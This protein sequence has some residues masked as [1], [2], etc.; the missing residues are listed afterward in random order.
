MA[1]TGVFNALHAAMS[2]Y[3]GRFE[4][5]E[6]EARGVVLYDEEV[7]MEG[8]PEEHPDKTTRMQALHMKALL[9]EGRQAEEAC[10]DETRALQR[11]QRELDAMAVGQRRSIR[12]Q[13][14]SRHALKVQGMEREAQELRQQ[15]D[16]EQQSLDHGGPDAAEKVT[17][18][19]DDLSAKIRAAEGESREMT[20]RALAHSLEQD[21]LEVGKSE[22]EMGVARKA[23]SLARDKMSAEAAEKDGDLLNQ[24]IKAQLRR[25]A[26]LQPGPKRTLKTKALQIMQQTAKDRHAQAKRALEDLEGELYEAAATLP[27]PTGGGMQ[28]RSTLRLVPGAVN[29]VCVDVNGNDLVD[30][31]GLLNPLYVPPIVAQ[32]REYRKRQATAMQ[33]R[34][35]GKK[36][37]VM[38]SA[39]SGHKVW[40]QAVAEQEAKRRTAAKMPPSKWK[41]AMQEA[42]KR[43]EAAVVATERL[44]KEK[45]SLS[46]SISEKDTALEHMTQLSEGPAGSSF[47]R[48]GWDAEAEEAWA[49]GMHRLAQLDV[50]INTQEASVMGAETAVQ[51]AFLSIY[52]AEL[53]HSDAKSLSYHQHA[54]EREA[55][56]QVVE[57]HR[58]LLQKV[59]RWATLA[60]SVADAAQTKAAAERGIHEAHTTVAGT[61]GTSEEK[62]EALNHAARKAAMA[63]ILYLEAQAQLAAAD[64]RRAEADASAAEAD[65]AWKKEAA[66]SMPPGRQR[67]V[68]DSHVTAMEQVA[69]AKATWAQSK[70]ALLPAAKARVVAAKKVLE[71]V[72]AVEDTATGSADR[73]VIAAISLAEQA[74]D[75]WVAYFEGVISAEERVATAESLAADR[76]ARSEAEAAEAGDAGSGGLGHTENLDIDEFSE[77]FGED[78]RKEKEE[79]KR[80]QEKKETKKDKKKKPDKKAKRREKSDKKVSSKKGDDRED[81]ALNSKAMRKKMLGTMIRLEEHMSSLFDDEDEKKEKKKKKHKKRRKKGD[82]SSSC[83]S[84]VSCSEADDTASTDSESIDDESSTASR[85]HRS[86]SRS[87]ASTRDQRGRSS[88]QKKKS[89]GETKRKPK[90]GGGGGSD[91]ESADNSSGESDAASSAS[92]PT[93]VEEDCSETSDS[94]P[95][96]QSSTVA[97]AVFKQKKRKGTAKGNQKDRSN[98]GIE[99][100]EEGDGG[101]WSHEAGRV[102]GY[103]E[104]G[105]WIGE[106]A[107]TTDEVSI[108]L[109]GFHDSFV[110]CC[111]RH[112]SHACLCRHLY[113][114]I[115]AAPAPEITAALKQKGT[116]A[117][118]GSAPQRGRKGRDKSAE[119]PQAEGKGVASGGGMKM[120]L[121]SELDPNHVAWRDWPEVPDRPPGGWGQASHDLESS[122]LPYMDT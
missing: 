28:A 103:V 38:Q 48:G 66:A 42:A 6:A 111:V 76:N 23:L 99:S 2:V 116:A 79:N 62:A 59:K 119:L 98:S 33:R 64:A 21:A 105:E 106:R 97:S 80:K 10:L 57:N 58:D 65:A 90:K 112:G 17:K 27:D 47:G 7:A 13:A 104:E 107:Q 19:E 12:E 102:E 31:S 29:F 114:D 49:G 115:P 85:S 43:G 25:I 24:N 52:E 18:A 40:Q 84:A 70:A 30:A 118:K 94:S 37:L 53:S 100:S 95:S 61:P 88:T 11:Q 122:L 77:A 83:S 56:L 22:A 14:V 93:S 32:D 110:C 20:S 81:N 91:S 34:C 39:M 121:W 55:A 108:E 86:R 4:A 8:M 60:L 82:S 3:E 101:E 73:G 87:G 16:Q 44:A 46:L 68:L 96:H 63:D 71:A 78:L 117:A 67:V 5:A 9:E 75:M 36:R 26:V 72:A 69:N 92:S 74:F 113:A 54:P 109:S 1:Q 89:S 120:V 45:M 15:Y 50:A 35:Q 51:E 41:L